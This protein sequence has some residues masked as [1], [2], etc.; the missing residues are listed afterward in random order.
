M[1][2]A[3]RGPGSPNGINNATYETRKDREETFPSR[4]FI[5]DQQDVQKFC[6]VLMGEFGYYLIAQDVGS[7]A[8]HTLIPRCR[9][10]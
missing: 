4:N 1:Y 10:T 3:V 5:L 6:R 2:C 8:T 9:P 7:R